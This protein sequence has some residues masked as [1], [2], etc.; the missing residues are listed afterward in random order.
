MFIFPTQEKV[1][2][3]NQDIPFLTLVLP[4]EEKLSMITLH[5]LFVIL[6]FLPGLF[7]TTEL[8]YCFMVFFKF[9]ELFA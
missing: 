3:S 9:P 1:K 4:A 6:F 8:L 5:V 7:H 2:V